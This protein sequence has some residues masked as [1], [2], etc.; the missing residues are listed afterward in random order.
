MDFL[1][2]F[3]DTFS[4]PVRRIRFIGLF[5][6]GMCRRCQSSGVKLTN[7]TVNSVPRF[8]NAWMQRSV[9]IN[10]SISQVMSLEQTKKPL[11]LRYISPHDHPFKIKNC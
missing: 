2:A 3:R 9:R 6:T 11:L 1:K 4:R 8:E 5:D 7:D 10:P